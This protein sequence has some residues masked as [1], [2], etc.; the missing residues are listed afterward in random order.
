MLVLAISEAEKPLEEQ[1]QNTDGWEFTVPKPK[2][3][4]KSWEGPS[5]NDK[6]NLAL[7]SVMVPVV[8]NILCFYDDKLW[9]LVPV[10]ASMA[11]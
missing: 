3:P 6:D 5:N 7:A 4:T 9:I 10:V 11:N 8:A 2:T 1:H